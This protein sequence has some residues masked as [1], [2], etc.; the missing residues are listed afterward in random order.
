MIVYYLKLCAD[1]VLAPS[2]ASTVHDSDND[3]ASN[4]LW[5]KP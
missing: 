1:H 2:I 3:E 5:G 4:V